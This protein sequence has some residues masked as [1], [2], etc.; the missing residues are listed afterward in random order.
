[1]PVKYNLSLVLPCSRLC[2]PVITCFP[3]SPFEKSFLKPGKILN[4][5]YLLRYL[6]FCG[7]RA[8]K[9]RIGV[10]VCH[11]SLLQIWFL[12][13]N[14][15]LGFTLTMS[16]SA[17]FLSQTCLAAENDI[18]TSSKLFYCQLCYVVFHHNSSVKH[19]TNSLMIQIVHIQ[20]AFYPD[21]HVT[22]L[23]L[24]LS[25]LIVFPTQ[26]YG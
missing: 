9:W 11:K 12:C 14:S 23:A 19:Q 1:M 4:I 8:I 20:A 21:S 6:I 13:P 5:P 2:A 16:F 25:T 7:R 17:W 26:H 18:V 22:F 15:S 24:W 3:F 10:S